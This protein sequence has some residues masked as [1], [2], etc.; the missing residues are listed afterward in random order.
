MCPRALVLPLSMFS[1]PEPLFVAE[2]EEKEEPT[3]TREEEA[4]RVLAAI[5]P[6]LVAFLSDKGGLPYYRLHRVVGQAITWKKFIFVSESTTHTYVRQ[7]RKAVAGT[8][9]IWS[10]HPEQVQ[11]CQHLRASVNTFV[12]RTVGGGLPC[13]ARWSLFGLAVGVGLLYRVLA[14]AG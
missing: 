5:D 6:G 9:S 1:C 10:L 4:E 8:F 11:A 14:A 12:G 3:E 2:P 7:E 13:A